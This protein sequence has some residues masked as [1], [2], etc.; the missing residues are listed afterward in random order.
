MEEAYL[1]S[2]SEAAWHAIN[3]LLESIG[4]RLIWEKCTIPGLIG[5]IMI[6]SAILCFMGLFSVLFT[7]ALALSIGILGYGV[8]APVVFLLLGMVFG[9]TTL[10]RK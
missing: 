1:L 2:Y 8:V 3:F 4:S 9:R 10:L 5:G 7:D 6:G